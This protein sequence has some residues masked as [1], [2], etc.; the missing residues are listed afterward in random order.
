[1]KRKE[2]IFSIILP[3]TNYKSFFNQNKELI[4]Q[5]SKDFKKIYVLNVINLKYRSK[6]KNIINGKLF[7]KN[8]QCVNFSNSKS[9]LNFFKYREC[10][11][12]QYLSKNPDFFKIFYLIKLAKIKNIMIM[13]LGNYGNKQTPDFNIKHIFAFRHYYEKGFYY[14][15]RI[16]TILNIFPKIELLFES[17]TKTINAHNNGLSKK[18]ENLFLFLKYLTLEK[19]SK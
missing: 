8:Y 5:L 3:T 19:L 1:M 11:A 6:V 2:K 4:I 12:L 15:F 14:L 10:V 16:L 18:F 9:F 13:N 17:N 7:P